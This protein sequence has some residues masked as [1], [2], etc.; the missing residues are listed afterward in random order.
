MAL[1]S[2]GAI[3]LNQ[4]HVEV[5][6]SSG[7]TVSLNDSD[8]RGLISKSSGATMA[9]NEWYGASSQ[10]DTFDINASSFT[11]SGAKNNPTHQ[12]AGFANDASGNL[13]SFGSIASDN[14]FPIASGNGTRFTVYQCQTTQDS[15]LSGLGKFGLIGNHASSDLPNLTGY[16]TIRSSNG[17]TTYITFNSGQTGTYDSGNNKTEWQVSGTNNLPTSGT[18]TLKLYT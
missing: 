3:S 2:S 8:I 15:I 5:G 6:G 18:V 17:N 16:N 7:S 9:F 14:N 4:M 10:T 11:P 12:G 1:P 13:Q